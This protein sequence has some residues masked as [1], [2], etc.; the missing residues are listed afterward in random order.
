MRAT[1]QYRLYPTDAQRTRLERI[2]ET[3]RRF[4]NDLLA[5]RKQ[6]WEECRETITRTQQLRQVKERKAGNPFAREVHSHILQVVVTDLDRAFAAFFRRVKAAEQPGCPRF[7]SRDR[8]RGFGLK[9]LGNG[10]RIDG[11]RLYVH[12]VG[13]LHV[14]W[15]R[16]V[17][18]VIKTLRLVERAGHWYACLSCASEPSPLEP[19]GQT[20]GIDVGLARLLTTSEGERVENP[21]WYRREQRALR[22]AQR[23][24]AR[25]KKGGANRRKAVRRLARAHERIRNRR[26]DFLCKLAHRLIGRYDVIALENLAITR[27]VHGTLAKSIL[28]AGWGYLVAHLTHRAASAG[29]VVILVDP[30]YTS[31]TCSACGRR[32]DHL[33][34]ADRWVVCP[35]GL[36]LDRDHNAAR[37]IRNRAGHVR[38]A[39]TSPLGGVAQEAAPL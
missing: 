9:E 18:G 37:N 25:R 29:R 10:F 5:E 32:F 14:R 7:K 3:C 28:D 24:V 33:T 12:G 11:R 39:A 15:H 1:Y 2:R 20:V 13:R 19:T 23:R 31:K 36:S 16:P 34:L 22:V 35:C 26:K 6:A 21:R 27:L 30:A 38:C 17:Q 8:F 4:Y